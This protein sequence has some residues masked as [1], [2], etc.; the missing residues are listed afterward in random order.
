MN[1]NIATK[2]DLMELK[3]ELIAKLKELNQPESSRNKKYLRSAQV[4]ELFSISAG[5]LQNMRVSNVLP[6]SK[7]GSTFFYDYDLII[8]ILQENKSA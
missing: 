5:T 8:E 6:Y 3:Q 7:I 1:L 4:R 2:E